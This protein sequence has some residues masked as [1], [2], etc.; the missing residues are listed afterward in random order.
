MVIW[1][2]G[3]YVCFKCM[4]TL[5]NKR[6]QEYLFLLGQC[7]EIIRSKVEVKEESKEVIIVIYVMRLIKYIK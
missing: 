6:A 2:N 7:Y 5:Y 4:G 3:V 1:D